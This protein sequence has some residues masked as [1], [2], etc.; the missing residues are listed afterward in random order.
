VSDRR[1]DRRI[2]LLL[3]VFGALFAVTL[4]RAAWV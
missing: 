3:V 2:H 4:G 1:P